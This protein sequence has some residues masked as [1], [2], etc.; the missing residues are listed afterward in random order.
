MEPILDIMQKLLYIF[1][2][3]FSLYGCSEY[4]KILKSND[5]SLKLQKANSWKSRT[6]LGSIE[7][8]WVCKITGISQANWETVSESEFL[9][10]LEW[11]WPRTDQFSQRENLIPNILG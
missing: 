5:F 3:I 7:K 6:A 11:T 4:Q 9:N 10:S 2:F 8:T 1:I